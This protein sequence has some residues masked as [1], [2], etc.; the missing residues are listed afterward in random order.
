MIQEWSKY[1]TPEVLSKGIVE[2]IDS[3]FFPNEVVDICV[4]SGNM[5]SSAKQRW[6]KASLVGVDIKLSKDIDSLG[7]DL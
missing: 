5:L 4:G 3:S 6:P 2:G 1:Y 7:F